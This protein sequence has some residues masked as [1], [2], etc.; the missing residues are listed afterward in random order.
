MGEAKQDLSPVPEPRGIQE[1]AAKKRKKEKEKKKKK[2]EKREE[3]EIP[4]ACV[5]SYEC[6]VAF[7]K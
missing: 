3:G 6:G 2:G 5:H 4:N 7:V 1:G